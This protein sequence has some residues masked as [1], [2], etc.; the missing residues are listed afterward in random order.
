MSFEIKPANRK[1]IV[2]LVCLYALSGC[3]KTYSALLMARGLAGPKGKVVIADTQSGQANLYAEEKILGGYEVLDFKE[4]FGPLRFIQ[5]LDDIEAAGAAVGII[6]SGSHE[7][8]GV[9]G[10]CWQA[11]ENEERSGKAGLH[12]WRKPKT[13]HEQFIQRLQRSRIPIIICLRAKFKTRQAKE[14]GK[15]IITKDDH[16]TEIQHEGFIYEMLVHGEIMPDHSL[17]LTK[18][19]HS[20]LLNCFPTNA[21]IAIEHGEALARWCE[22]AGVSPDAQKPKTVPLGERKAILSRLWTILK[23]VRG[24]GQTWDVAQQW[25]W[26][27]AVMDPNQRITDLS[28]AEL[29]TITKKAEFKLAGDGDLIP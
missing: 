10:V 17:R 4:P 7:W 29:E 19:M 23:S 18:K 2:P 24:T 22:N 13:D 15:T 6:D 25:L 14:N 5:A 11:D 8:E 1:G 3:G 26:D 27:E 16:T 12:N 20:S 28:P 9:G 21:P